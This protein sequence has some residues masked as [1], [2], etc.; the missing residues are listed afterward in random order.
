MKHFRVGKNAQVVVYVV[1]IQLVIVANFEGSH[2]STVFGRAYD[3]NYTHLNPENLLPDYQAF[4]EA[5]ALLMASRAGEVEPLDE[6]EELSEETTEADEVK[7]VVEAF[8]P[9]NPAPVSPMVD[10]KLEPVLNT[11]EPV[12]EV[13]TSKK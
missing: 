13:P 11:A 9:F 7:D 1:G 10:P 4:D 6:P 5:E 8:N 3:G 12:V 2:K